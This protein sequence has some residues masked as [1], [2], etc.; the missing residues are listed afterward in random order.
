MTLISKHDALQNLDALML[1]G[2]RFF[3]GL[4][5]CGVAVCLMFPHMLCL[6]IDTTDLLCTSMLA[7]LHVIDKLIGMRCVPPQ[8]LAGSCREKGAV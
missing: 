7:R 6:V 4:S 3:Q 1:I 2:V 8:G 5:C